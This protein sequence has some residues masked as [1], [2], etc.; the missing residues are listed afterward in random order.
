ME[1]DKGQG[2]Y[3]V[4]LPIPA[5]TWED[6]EGN[7]VSAGAGELACDAC[8]NGG[9]PCAREA[10]TGTYESR[11]SFIFDEPRWDLRWW[12]TRRATVTA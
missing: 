7:V 3:H 6:T 9:E 11:M 5:R 10:L 4:Q 8:A 12:S 1:Y 2:L